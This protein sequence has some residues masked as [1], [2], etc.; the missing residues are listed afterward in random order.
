M[1]D[2]RYAAA[3]QF[4]EIIPEEVIDHWRDRTTQICMVELVATNIMFETFKFYLRS[5]TV[6][7]LVDSEAVE[8]ALVKGYSSRSDF[9][10]LVGLFWEQALALSCL[11]Y[12]DRNPTDANCSDY[13]SR[14]KLKIGEAVGWQTVSARWPKEIKSG[15]RA[16]D[17]RT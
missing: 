9:C 16:W 12:I 5:S 17:A 13:P 1:F 14:N 4:T 8:G 10:E 2:R 15:G 6:L 11:I 3:V 7:L